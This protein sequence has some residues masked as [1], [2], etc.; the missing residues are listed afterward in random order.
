MIKL[1]IEV[2]YN[3]GE[4]ITYPIALPEWTKW[5]RKTGKSVFGFVGVKADEIIQKFQI[6]DFLF[7]AHSSYVR[8][9]AGSPT[10]PYDIW[11]LTVD[12]VEVKNPSV[13]KVSSSEV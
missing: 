6:N 4:A 3:S 8:Q 11:E 10:K 5:E 9:A 1:D 13:P 2:T 12:G 7:L